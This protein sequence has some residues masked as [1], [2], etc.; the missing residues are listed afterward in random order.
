M[1]KPPEGHIKS[2]HGGEVT[3]P[4]SP[5]DEVRVDKRVLPNSRLEQLRAWQQELEDACL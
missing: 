2:A 4:L 3:P 5:D 1:R